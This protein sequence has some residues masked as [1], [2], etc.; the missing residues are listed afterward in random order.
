MRFGCRRPAACTPPPAAPPCCWD[1]R[2][3]TVL[4]YCGCCAV[5]RREEIP[6]SEPISYLS[7]YC[8]PVGCTLPALYSTGAT[9]ALT[10]CSASAHGAGRLAG[11][12]ASMCVRGRARRRAAIVH[13]VVEAPW[14]G[15]RAAGAAAALRG[16]FVH[17]CIPYH[18]GVL[19]VRPTQSDAILFCWFHRR[20]C[21]QQSGPCCAGITCH[22]MH[23]MTFTISCKRMCCQSQLVMPPFA[24]FWC[25]PAMAHPLRCRRAV[26]CHSLPEPTR[27]LACLN[28]VGQRAPTRG[29]V[30]CLLMQLHLACHCMQ[31]GMFAMPKP[32]G[33]LCVSTAVL[34][35]HGQPEEVRLALR[36]MIA[37][38]RLRGWRAALRRCTPL[39]H[40]AA[41][42]TMLEPRCATGWGGGMGARP[43][44]ASLHHYSSS[45]RAQGAQGTNWLEHYVHLDEM[46]NAACIK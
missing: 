33:S 44:Q 9:S 22:V 16:V 19:P 1:V 37:G 43:L 29:A 21:R 3:C 13:C 10:P 34:C 20:R 39:R 30:A 8:V 38:A 42:A 32:G 2:L 45:C 26:Y 27:Q 25:P 14:P 5:P 18:T 46:V 7:S 23:D 12:D 28:C 17:V 24:P 31:E 40:T 15:R 4:C 41:A 11:W 35:C 36:A 6:D